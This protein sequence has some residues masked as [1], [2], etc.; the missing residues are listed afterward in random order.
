MAAKTNHTI[1]QFLIFSLLGLLPAIGAAQE[2]KIVSLL[3]Q[4]L[5]KEIRRQKKDPE[6][7]IG[8]FFEV[9]RN[10]HI[11]MSSINV[12]DI[13]TDSII[14]HSI[15]N[16]IRTI[17]LIVRKKISDSDY[18]IEKQ[19]VPLSKIKAISKDI[20]ILLETEPDAVTVKTTVNGTVTTHN[21][22]LFFLYLSYNK[23]NQELAEKL[24]SAFKKAGYILK[25]EYW[26]D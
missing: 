19:E 14:Q 12:N 25:N 26:Y 21:T 3:N 17:S 5:Q 16:N 6:N 23:Q 20:N 7:Y 4:E 2:K 15:T 13:P 24:I 18:A 10:Y 11:G 22:D 9:L 1:K 8:P